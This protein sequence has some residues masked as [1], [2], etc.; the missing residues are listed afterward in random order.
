MAT[1]ISEK[2]GGPHAE[3]SLTPWTQTASPT[4]SC[5]CLFCNKSHNSRDS[6]V[7]H[8]QFHYQMVLVCP[9]CGG[10]GL[11]QW[12]TVEGHVKKCA[13]AHPNIVSRKVEPGEPHWMSSDPPLINHTWVPETEATF[14]LP[15]WPDPQNNE[16]AVHQGQI[17]ECI[18]KEWEAQITTIKKAAAAEAE[19]AEGSDKVDDAAAN[20][21]DSKPATSKPKQSL[22]HSKKKP[23]KRVEPLDDNLN[24]Y[25]GPSQS[26]DSQ[27]TANVTPVDTPKKSEEAKS[28]N[29]PDGA[30]RQRVDKPPEPPM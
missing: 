1:G 12:R 3:D 4:L 21:D 28:K 10:C 14:T 16:E 18:C 5:V 26:Q 19:K 15:V 29:D 17:F 2:M 7:Y 27:H 6:L 30:S 8:L 13:A 9:I 20:K 24:D 22:C 11:N 23:S 25:F